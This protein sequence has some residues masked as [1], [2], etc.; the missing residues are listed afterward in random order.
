MAAPQ[1]QQ[2]SLSV[3]AGT[4]GTCGGGLTGNGICPTPSECC[5]QYGFCGT[6]ADHCSNVAPVS[7]PKPKPGANGWDN[8]GAGNGSP[9]MAGT[10]GG[11]STGNGICANGVECC[12]SF[13]FCGT[14]AEHCA[15]RAPV[16]AAGQQ[17]GGQQQYSPQQYNPQQT[18]AQQSQQT[19]KGT[20]GG[21]ATG[22]G[23]C[24]VPDECCSVHGFCGTSLAHCT[25]RY[26]PNSVGVQAAQPQQTQQ[27]YNPPPTQQQTYN[28]PPTQQT[29]NPPPTLPTFQQNF[30]QPPPTMG[31][32]AGG[33]GNPPSTT[34]YYED[35]HSGTVGGP[36]EAR[37][38]YSKGPQSGVVG[39]VGGVPQ[40]MP[41][42]YPPVRP[43]GT[44]KKILG[45]VSGR[46]GE[47]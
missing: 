43:H 29:Y 33:A 15:N 18:G 23:F 24:Q 45:Y 11:G 3:S 34:V 42:R 39:E 38:S 30:P 7:A 2:A 16:T 37:I 35:S 10:C 1:T 46:Q 44:N 31:T 21:G 14:S 19:A 32:A 5:S 12:S 4:K 47:R 22:N 20:C 6:S 41:P 28:P 8:N 17:A 27:A 40:V 25:N 13:G 9:P 36:Y 26:D